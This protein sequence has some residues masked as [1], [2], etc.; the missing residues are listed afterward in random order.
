MRMVLAMLWLSLALVTNAFA[1]VTCQQWGNNVTC[2]DSS[3]GSVNCT[4]FGNMTNC[5]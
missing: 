2:Q 4:S 5:Y 1:Y 3:G